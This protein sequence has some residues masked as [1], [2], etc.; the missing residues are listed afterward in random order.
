LPDDEYAELPTMLIDKTL[1]KMLEPHANENGE[2]VNTEIGIVHILLATIV[3][4]VPSQLIRSDANV[5]SA[6]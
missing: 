6:F 5:P 3:V 2:L 1:A 4:F